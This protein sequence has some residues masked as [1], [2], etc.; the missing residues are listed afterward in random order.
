MLALGLLMKLMPV[1]LRG[2][3]ARLYN[4]CRRE[5]YLHDLASPSKL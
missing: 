2:K 4:H 5:L 1:D 3:M